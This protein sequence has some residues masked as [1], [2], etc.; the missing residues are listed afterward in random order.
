MKN[1]AYIFKFIQK[2]KTFLIKLSDRIQTLKHE[3]LTPK[4]VD[5]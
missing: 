4:I 3:Y 5:F 2:N 1:Q